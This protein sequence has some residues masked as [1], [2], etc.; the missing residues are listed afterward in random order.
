VPFRGFNQK[1]PP[2]KMAWAVAIL[3]AVLLIVGAG[4]G[5]VGFVIFLT[6]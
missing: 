1:P 6:V 3:L 5:L 2:V 4:Y